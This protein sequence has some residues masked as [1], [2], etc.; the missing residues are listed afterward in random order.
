MIYQNLIGHSAK[1][2]AQLDKYTIDTGGVLSRLLLF[3]KYTLNSVR[4]KEI[5]ELVKAFGLENTISL[6]KSEAL[7]I[8]LSPATTA[9][10]GQTTILKSRGQKGTLPLCSYSF[11]T[12]DAADRKDYVH[13]CFEESVNTI[14]AP[15]K[16]LIKLKRAILEK[17][18]S[19]TPELNNHAAQQL[20]DDLIKN[21]PIIK[22]AIANRLKLEKNLEITDLEVE[23]RI[24][25]IDEDDF[26][27]ESN[28]KK[29][30]NLD[31]NKTHKL[32]ELALLDIAGLNRRI[33]EMHHFN[34]LSS[35]NYNDLPIFEKKLEFLLSPHDPIKHEERA[36]R[37]FGALNLPDLNTSE[38]K[39]DIQRFLEIR[40]SKEC[41]AFREWLKNIDTYSDLEIQ[42]QLLNFNS[43][44]STIA[45]TKSA[46]TLRFIT[47]N[48]IGA[49]P[50]IGAALGPALSILDSYLFN[51]LLKESP[52]ATFALRTYP[53]L[54]NK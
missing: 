44:I 13:R 9:Q 1:K 29:K 47:T 10:T 32:I 34:A 42:E 40:A 53:S 30:F 52:I 41:I 19:A 11:D 6:I 24:I 50:V 39:I 37:A 27:T 43:K 26:S 38:K 25:Q 54:F 46:K 48:A 2:D 35:F 17:L 20:K 4:L 49:L 31:E 3:E 21:S 5:P 45:H 51:T 15:I 18:K 22:T 36:K 33:A 12:I 14:N 8:Y 28:L 7:D 23:L 16:D